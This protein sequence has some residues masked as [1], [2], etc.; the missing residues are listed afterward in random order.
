M[1]NTIG[2]TKPAAHSHS[3]SSHAQFHPSSQK[4][5]NSR[6]RNLN[7]NSVG[8]FDENVANLSMSK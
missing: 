7:E 6:R 1:Q 3:N 5:M 2:P 4:F 8:A